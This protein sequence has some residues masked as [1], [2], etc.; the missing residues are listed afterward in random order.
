MES[1]LPNRVPP[2]N[3]DAEM[4]VL[5]S[6]M[7]DN[8]AYHQLEGM[9]LPEMFYKEAHRKIF[10]VIETLI[11]KNSPA[12]LVTVIEELRTK[13]Q[14]DEIGGPSYLVGLSEAVPTSVYANFYGKIVAEK[15][16]LRNLI[17]ASSKVLQLAFDEAAPV[18]ELMDRAEKLIFEV[19]STKQQQAFQAM[20]QLVNETFEFISTLTNN[21]GFTTGVATGF[22]DLDEMTTGLQPGSL[23]VIAARPSM[24]KCLTAHTLIDDPHTGERIKL[25]TYILEKRSCVWGVADDGRVRPTRVS[26]WID[27]GIQPVYR[28]TTRLGRSVEVTGHH[29]FLTVDGWTPLHDLS[30]GSSIAVPREMPG[31][32]DDDRT[33]LEQVRLIAYLIAEGG[34][35]DSSPEWTNTDPVLI[36]DFSSII[37]AHFP[38]LSLRWQDITAIIARA[39]TPGERKNQKNP[40]TEWLRE[41]GLW[42][43]L[44]SEKVFP[45]LVWRYDETRLAEFLRVLFSCDATIYAIGPK[46]S[47][48]I[49]F[50]VA[51]E[52]LARDVQHALVRFGIV[53]KLWQKTAKSWRVEITEPASIA[54]YQERIGW[55]GEKVSRDFAIQAAAHSNVGHV[56]KAVWNQVRQAARVAN[57]SLTELARRA[58]ETTTSGYNAHTNRNL[59][60]HRLLEYANILENADL[61]K[62]AHPNLYWDTITKI[63]TL[64]AQQVYDLTVPDGSNFIAQD[65][66]VH[67]TAFALAV[68]QN[69]ALKQNKTV[70]VFSLEMPAS[71]LVLRMLCNEARV[72]M[73]RVRQGSLNERDFERLVTAAG[74]LAEA[75]IFIDDAADLNV[76]ELRSKSRRLMAERDLKMI[77]IDYLQLMT[78]GP[79]RGGGGGEN[80]QQEISTI[81]R[82]LKSLARELNIP[83][84]VLSQ[85]SRAVESRPNHRPMLSDLRECVT[86]DTLVML[87][88][89]RRVPIQDLVGQIPRVLSMTLDGRLLETESD[90]V[91]STG[92]KPVFELR[93]S[94]GRT[95]RATANHRLLGP[96]GWLELE[97]FAPGDRIAIARRTMEVSSSSNDWSDSRLAL[98]AHLIGD[99]SFIKHQPL[100]Y[101]TASEDNSRIVTEAALEFGVRVSRHAG[102][103]NW[104]Q[105]VFSGNGNRWHPAGINLWLRNL[106]IYGQRSFEKHVPSEI[107]SLENT[108]IATFVRHLWATDGTISVRKAGQRGSAAV[109]FSTNSER[110]ARDVSALLLRLG[111]VARLRTV[112]QGKHRP[113]FTVNVSG[114]EDQ[115]R[116]LDVVG[117]FGPKVVQAQAL[118][119]SLRDKTANTNVDTLPNEIFEQVK[120]EMR[121]QGISQREMASRRGTAYGGTSHFKF[122]PSRATVLE[123][124]EILE[125]EPLKTMARSDIFWDEVL[126]IVPMGEAEVFD[127]TVPETS[128]WLAD[129]IVSHN[130]GAI[131]QDADL[132]AFIY[133]DEYYDKNSEK[134]GIAEIIIGKQRNGPVGTVELQFHSQHVRFNDLAKD[135]V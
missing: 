33:S 80:R 83:V 82:N 34:L 97:Q 28:V 122:A 73:N 90:L 40:L 37:A 105:L 35:T 112:A 42:G 114:L 113:M 16:A 120:L 71:Q 20:P 64:E 15:A 133:R 17:A 26:A 92:V 89:G 53:A 49:E 43:K 127:L 8:D 10:T 39:H 46:R 48:R 60:Q 99:G 106:G 32:G 91:W 30:V 75:P 117:A 103:G 2:N 63:E 87:A 56:P 78:S 6:I 110:L 93:T 59:P 1:G 124:A 125:S 134:Q 62:L 5:G 45:E 116:F 121:S 54:R 21:P 72:D 96:K 100:R 132:V 19:A 69:I 38:E 88:D 111:I 130:S 22:R 102:R 95:I 118:S 27:S 94:S 9:I 77:V 23:N 18:E 41:L 25:E 104:H 70:A 76:I 13:G 58:G 115:R 61:A 14:L 128:A 52:T 12:D 126:E 4:S 68:A 31:F 65:V 129:G 7:L 101:T 84:V 50:T 79:S 55:I 3:L 24:G 51:S 57:I 85:L 86:G 131:E 98:L 36:Q 109:N 67:N 123:Y 135:G 66:C 11:N 29:P 44:S 74:K 81:S 108:A 107:Y 119:E 47:A